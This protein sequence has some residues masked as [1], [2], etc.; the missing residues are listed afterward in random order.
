MISALHDLDPLLPALRIMM[1]GEAKE[2]QATTSSGVAGRFVG[3]SSHSS[4]D[5][6]EIATAD[7]LDQPKQIRFI[8]QLHRERA[9]PSPLIG[10]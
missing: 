10:D 5:Y 6:S 4:K 7:C 1:H 2:D 9:G 8:E 3:K